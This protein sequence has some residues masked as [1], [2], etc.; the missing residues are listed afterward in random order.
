[1]FLS[2]IVLREHSRL[3]DAWIVL[4]MICY[5]L[6]TQLLYN[7]LYLEQENLRSESAQMQALALH[8]S[9]TGIPNRRGFEQL[10]T[11]ILL[12]EDS[13]EYAVLLIDTDNFKVVNDTHGHLTGDAVLC[14]IALALKAMTAQF[15]GAVCARLGGDEFAVFI[16]D[17]PVQSVQAGADEFRLAVQDAGLPG[18]LGDGRTRS[19]LTATVS[20]GIAMFD[21]H[22]LPLGMLLRA[23]DIALYRAKDGGRDRVEV[24]FPHR[25]DDEELQTRLE[26]YPRVGREPPASAAH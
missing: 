21:R 3:A 13:A 26:T 19:S 16:P 17:Q 23:A 5:L 8:D 1:M 10:V 22:H 14:G 18:E 20:I 12:R 4:T 6:R 7:E 24:V 15:E 9:L 2:L 25:V 11:E